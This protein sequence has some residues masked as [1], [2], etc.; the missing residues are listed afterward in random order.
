MSVRYRIFVLEPGEVRAR[1]GTYFDHESLA[2]MA[3]TW[4]WIKDQKLIV[5]Y[6]EEQTD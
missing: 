3:C 6:F 2:R 1:L 5:G 4:E